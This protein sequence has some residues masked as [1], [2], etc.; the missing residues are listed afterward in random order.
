MAARAETSASRSAGCGRARRT[1]SRTSPASA[2]ATRRSSRATTSARVSRSSTPPPEPLFAGCHR[3]N[4]NGELTGL[5]WIRESGLLTSRSRSRTRTRSGVVRDALIGAS[6]AGRPDWSLPVV[7]ETWDGFLN[8]I[9]GFHVRAGARRGR[10]RARHASG[11]VVEG[12]VG[13]G[14]GM[15][16]HGFKGGIGTSSRSLEDGATVGVSCRRTTASGAAARERRARRRADRAGASPVPQPG[17]EGAGSIIVL[18]A[19]D[20]PLLPGQ[21]E[22]LARRAG[23]RDRADRR[24]GRDLERR[25]RALLRHRQPRPRQRRARARAP[26]CEATSGSTSCT[27]PSIDAVEE[28]I[29]NALLAAETMT[30]HGGNTAYAACERAS[31]LARSAR[32]T[33]GRRAL[34]VAREQHRVAAAARRAARSWV[35]ISAT[36]PPSSTTIWSASR[37]VESRCAI[38][39]VVRPSA[40]CSSA[41]CTSALRLRVERG[42][43]LVEHED[44]RVA[45]HGPRDRDPLLLAAREAVA[46]LADDRVVALRQRRD[47][48]VDL[49]G[50]GSLLDLLVGRVRASRSGGCRAPTRGRGTSPARRRRPSRQRLEGEVADVDAVDRRRCRR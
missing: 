6:A 42:R 25:L 7:G 11:P 38:A 30:G 22:R 13:G 47:Q 32:A 26:R 1:R 43:R 14:T 39:I 36:R 8:D 24:D 3:I 15:I 23:L 16:C 2:S 31:V 50:A 48:V 45:Q 49:R 29:V 27:R 19:T 4:G 12:A 18:V 34:D 9:N 37:T 10:A 28:S 41:S 46:A 21:C 33:L 17:S 20:A 40:S 35:P 44:R 5:E